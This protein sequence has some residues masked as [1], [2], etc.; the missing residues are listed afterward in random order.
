MNGKI[1]LVA[2]ILFSSKVKEAAEALAIPVT[3]IKSAAQVAEEAAQN[4]AA[5]LIL[6]LN[7]TRVDPFELM[8]EARK[9]GLKR[10]M[11]FFSHVDTELAERA[12]A[13]GA[14]AVIP[15][16]Q[17]TKDLPALIKQLLS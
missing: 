3:S 16:S 9:A 4:P 14:E 15:R 1:L 17:F 6:D 13:E 2:D 8:A 11:C 10:I 12:H 7:A 5:A